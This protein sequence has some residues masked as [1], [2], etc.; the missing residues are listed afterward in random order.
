MPLNRPTQIELLD[1]VESYL[2]QPVED[3]KADGFY[4]RVASNVLA[5]VQREIE[6]APL[7][8]QQERTLLSDI[9]EKDCSNPNQALCDAIEQGSLTLDSQLTGTLLK[10]AEKKLQIDNPRYISGLNK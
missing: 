5:I 8:L 6:Q 3:P 2:R 4:R 9:L 10:L 1:A 7:L